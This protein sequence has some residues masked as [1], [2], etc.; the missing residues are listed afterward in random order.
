MTLL[1]YVQ[2]LQEQGVKDIPAKVEE[3]KKLNQPEVEEE[4]KIDPVVKTDALAP[5]KTNGASESLNSGDLAL[6]VSLSEPDDS[7][8]FGWQKN[9]ITP[10]KQPGILGKLDIDLSAKS[11]DEMTK[12]ID[13]TKKELYGDVEFIPGEIKKGNGDFEYKY[14]IVEEEGK[15]KREFYFKGADDNDWTNQTEKNRKAH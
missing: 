13:D 4:V 5:G 9:I 11:L 6:N 2:S 14:E 15:R 7:I 12:N 1:E 8:I 3:W 10:P